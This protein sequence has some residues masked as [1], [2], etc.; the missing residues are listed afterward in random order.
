MVTGKQAYD[1]G[2]HTNL[3]QRNKNN[4]KFELI[5]FEKCFEDYTLNK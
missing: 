4:G 1:M 5:R 3:Y 2:I